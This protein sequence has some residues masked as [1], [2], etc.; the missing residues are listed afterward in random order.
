MSLLGIDVG[1]TGCK[2]IAFDRSG[3]VLAESRREYPLLNPKPGYWELDAERVWTDVAATIAGVAAETAADPVEALAISAL[4]EAVVPVAFDRHP[5]AGAPVSADFRAAAQ[6]ERLT[7]A[8]GA[9]AIYA[10]TGQP[11]TAFYSLAKM[12]WWKEEAPELYAKAWKFLCFGDYVLARLGMDPVI[13]FSM[14]ARTL[15]FD[16]HRGEWSATILDAAGIAAEKLAEAKPSGVSIGRLPRE[17]AETL[18]LP[19][20][21]VVVTGGFDQACGALGVGVVDAGTGYY[22]LGTTEALALVVEPPFPN[23]EPLNVALCPHV[24]PGT[25]IAMAGSQTG[26]R[27]LRWFRDE[28]AAADAV[29][30]E[31]AGRSAYDVMAESF[32]AEPSP[33]IVL[34]HFTGS[35]TIHNDPTSR[36]AI[37]GLTFDTKRSDL[38]KAVVEGI[39]YEQA[40]CLARLAEEGVPI[41][42]LMVV[43]GGARS[44]IALQIKAD[45]LGRSLCRQGLSDASCLGAAMLAGLGAGIF[46]EIGDATRMIGGDS[47]TFIPDPIR[48]A[49][50][51]RR[52]EIYRGLYDS[53]IGAMR[54]LAA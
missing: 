44:D 46:A 33:L 29:V 45:I 42:R 36:G 20:S 30:A 12:M 21:V 52:L 14:A 23:L 39:T 15:A 1:T 8:L 53:L 35:G 3:R 19:A 6:M 32:P 11:P 22:G 26:G 49:I 4:G 7:G 5:L 51:A 43:G 41:D 2:T 37:L 9:S 18:G 50:Y 38:A 54:A 10:I 13:D 16:I 47:R 40:F 17:A 27:L 24:A 25:M 28:F 48:H 31:A 34:P